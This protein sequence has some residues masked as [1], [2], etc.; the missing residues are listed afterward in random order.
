MRKLL[1]ML[2]LGLA[3]AAHLAAAAEAWPSRT[4]TLVA[5]GPAGG[6]SDVFARLLAEALARDLGVNV[7]VENRSGAATMIGTQFVAR[8]KPD[9]Y[10]LLVGAAALTIGPHLMKDIAIDPTRELQPIRVLARFP[11]VVVTHPDSPVKD[12]RGLIREAR[13]HPG[14]FNYASGGAGISEHLSGELFK[15]LTGVDLV[16]IPYKGS[17]DA[18]MAVV[19]GESLV[20]FANMPVAMPQLRAGKLRALAVTGASRS[21]VL[22]ELPT[23]AEAGVQGY[24]LSTWFGLLAPAGTPPEVVRRLDEATRRF[25]ES[26][27]ARDRLAKLGGDPADEGPDDFRR[28]L[29]ADYA[30]WGD[31]I[32]KANIRA[33]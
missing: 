31:L 28:T 18:V 1:A 24:E 8:A 10:T 3:A 33:D 26:A 30:K 22:G 5:P 20:A 19:K 15:S 9:G 12:V 11:N 2:L 7:I 27:L 17:A 25:L 13:A 6:T 16:H 23:V 4:I 32:R 14:R 29:A 21:T